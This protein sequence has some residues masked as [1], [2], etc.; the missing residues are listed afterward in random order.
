MRLREAEHPHQGVLSNSKVVTSARGAPPSKVGA[1]TFHSFSRGCEGRGRRQWG[2]KSCHS[3]SESSETAVR[4]GTLKTN[5]DFFSE[6]FKEI[7]FQWTRKKNQGFAATVG[8]EGKES[9]LR[10]GD[11]R[12]ALTGRISAAHTANIYRFSWSQEL[13]AVPMMSTQQLDLTSDT[14]L[15]FGFTGNAWQEHTWTI[16]TC[17][18]LSMCLSASLTRAQRSRICVFHIGKGG[19]NVFQPTARA[20]IT[21]YLPNE[22]CAS[23]MISI[24]S[25]SKPREHAKIQASNILSGNC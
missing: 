7:F 5:P 15:H 22:L 9:E 18:N 14:L 2:T 24:S 13:W 11:H 25:S 4:V 3:P 16:P 21:I 20:N 23:E 12:R 10:G 8:C 19:F 1:R 6:S 17:L